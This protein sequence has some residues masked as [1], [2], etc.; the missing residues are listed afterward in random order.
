VLARAS[1]QPID[2]PGSPD[3]DRPMQTRDI[4]FMMTF[5]LSAGGCISGAACAPTGSIHPLPPLGPEQV[6]TLTGYV[7]F[8]D[9]NDVSSLGGFFE[10]LPGATSSARHRT[11]ESGRPGAIPPSSR[12]LGDGRSPCR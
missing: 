4:V 10:I 11:G 7:Q 9:G 5:A 8:V 6:S 3:H 2:T 1:R 12:P